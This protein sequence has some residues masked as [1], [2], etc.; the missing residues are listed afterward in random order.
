MPTWYLPSPEVGC[1]GRSGGGWRV[2]PQM[3]N[4]AIVYAYAHT[5]FISLGRY[6]HSASRQH[7]YPGRY[8][9][10]GDKY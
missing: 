10:T 7:L 4:Y 1:F 6:I 8:Y 3:L 5:H 9:S 2:N